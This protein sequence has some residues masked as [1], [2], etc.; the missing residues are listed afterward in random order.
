M[1]QDSIRIWHD[2][3]EMWHNALTHEK[4]NSTMNKIKLRFWFNLNVNHEIWVSGFGHFQGCSNFRWI[5]LMTQS[6]CNTTQSECGTT[7]SK[8]DMIMPKCTMP[9]R[10]YSGLQYLY[11]VISVKIDSLPACVVALG[12]SYTHTHNRPCTDQDI[13]YVC[14]HTSHIVVVCD[15]LWY[16]TRIWFKT[17]IWYDSLC[18][19]LV[20]CD[21]S[22]MS[23]PS[24]MWRDMSLM[25][26]VS[27]MCDM[28]FM[29]DSYHIS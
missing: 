28:S 8:C 15:I 17:R 11:L 9:W 3:S 1:R 26:D 24:L 20:L 16:K 5:Y 12:P 27:F 2:S 22:P 29:C 10:G 6:N 4:H 25:C 23:Y 14:C 7:L 19:I 18:H 21:P 13:V